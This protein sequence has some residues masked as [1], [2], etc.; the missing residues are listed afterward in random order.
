MKLLY[1]T[2]N[3][4][5]TQHFGNKSSMYLTSHKGT[6]FRVHNDLKKDMIAAQNGT[7]IEAVTNGEE[8]FVWNGGWKRTSHYK[9]GSP[10]GNYVVIDHGG[11][12]TL[13][14]HLENVYVEN[15]QQ[16]KA[17]AVIGK[18]GNTGYSQG[19]HL[20]FELRDKKNSSLNAI[21]SEP[22]FTTSLEEVPE[23]G[24]EAWGWGKE[25]NI[26]SDMSFFDDNLTKGEMMVLLHRYH[27]NA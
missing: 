14:G 10:F 25:K 8:W 1:P 21:N 2:R 16:V 15:G 4:H 17:G 22:Y 19:A 3:P 27:K 24:K 18:G 5:I 7:V 11:Y 23:W 20:H 6:D 12:F 13:Y 9:K 26:L